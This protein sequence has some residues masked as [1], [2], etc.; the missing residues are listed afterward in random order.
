M[1][2]R[3]EF[4]SSVLLKDGGVLIA[5]SIGVK[6]GE[7]Y[8]PATGQFRWTGAVRTV[9]ENRTA[10]LLANGRVLLA[11]GDRNLAGA[12]GPI[13]IYRTAEIY[14]PLTG[15]FTSTGSMKNEREGDTATLLSDGKVLFAG[16]ED[17]DVSLNTAELYDP[18][19]GRFSY[20]GSMANARWLGSASVLRSGDVL[21]AGGL[22]ND[23]EALSS[24]ELYNPAAGTFD[25]TGS[26]TAGANGQ[27][28][29]TLNDGRVLIVGIGRP[30][31][32]VNLYWP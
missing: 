18:V 9:A 2:A 12:L 11:G 19:S 17:S 28:A 29:T 5:G 22:N 3:R 30:P 27:S 7:L 6:D 24:A 15:M 32:T 8:D 26:M 1:R 16:G 31:T 23:S 4:A 20:T 10:T 21:V 14:D 25:S 13:V